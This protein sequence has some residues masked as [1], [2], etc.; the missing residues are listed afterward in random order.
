MF[1][2][3]WKRLRKTNTRNSREREELGLFL[4]QAADAEALKKEMGRD[5]RTVSEDISQ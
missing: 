5:N 1:K 3:E 4:Y 2:D